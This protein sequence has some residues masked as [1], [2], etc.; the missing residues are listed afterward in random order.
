MNTLS[1]ERTSSMKERERVCLTGQMG[2]WSEALQPAATT[3]QGAPQVLESFDITPHPRCWIG[4]K[5]EN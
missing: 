5:G 2:V 3:R 1:T 4:P